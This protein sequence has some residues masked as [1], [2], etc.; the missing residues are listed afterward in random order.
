MKTILVPT[1]NNPA[2]RSTLETALLLAKRTGAYIEGV[3]LWF[4]GPEFVVAEQAST[5][6]M[7][8]AAR[9]RNGGRTQALRNL[10][11]GA[12][13]CSEIDHG[14]SCVW[15]VCRGAAR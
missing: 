14:P 5:F 9:R 1:Q 8:S 10:H 13:C 12:W 6:S 4:G 11:A 7:E 15:L 2:M 3:P